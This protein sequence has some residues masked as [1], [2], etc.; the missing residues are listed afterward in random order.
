MKVSYKWLK[1]YVDLSKVTPDELADKMS[2]TGIEIEEVDNL[3]DGLKKI[4]VGEV[5]ECVDHENSDHLHVCQ[6][7]VGKETLQIVCGA[8]NVQKGQKVIVALAGARIAGNMKIKKGKIRGEV[9]HG[10]LCS[11]E[12][13]G[14]SNSV[15][16]KEEQ[17]GIYILPDNSEPGT[18][19][20]SLLDLDDSILELAIT[21]NRA[22]ALSMKGVSYEVGAI[23]NQEVNLPT[24]QLTEDNEV[25][26]ELSAKVENSE[27]SSQYAVRYIKDVQIKPSP[28]WLQLRLMNMGIRP[29]NNVIDITNYIMLL[30]GQPLHAYDADTLRGTLTVQHA[31]NDEKFVALNEEEYT[32][33]SSDIVI[34]DDDQV[35]ALAGIMGSHKT[36]VTPKTTNICLESALFDAISIRKTSQ[37]LHLRTDASQRFEKG[38]D[39]L[40]VCEALDVAASMISDLGSGKVAKGTNFGINQVDQELPQITISLNKIN[41]GLG[42]ELPIS[43]VEMILTA[44][45][46]DYQVYGEQFVITIPSRRFDLHIEADIVEEIGRLYG[47]NNLPNKLPHL[48]ITPGKRSKELSFIHQTH[49]KLQKLGLKETINYALT[50]ENKAKAFNLSS[51][52]LINLSLPMS[53][54]RSVLR[55]NIIS[56]LLDTLQ[57]NIARKNNNLTIYEIGKI[58]TK[59][60][61]Y[62]EFN[63]L[64][65]AMIGATQESTWLA[66]DK[67]IDFYTLKGTIE[68]YLNSLGLDLEIRYVE[69]QDRINMHPYQTADIV[70]G[71]TCIG[72]LGKV[73]PKY[74]KD[75]DLSN[76]Y[77]SEIDLHKLLEMESKDLIAKEI[78]KFPSVS[79][80]VAL[81][82]DKNINNAQIEKV[83]KDNG[84]KYLSNIKIFDIYAGENI[85]YDKKS[86]A[87]KLQFQKND[88][89]LVDDEIEEIM[90]KI[91]TSL[92]KELDVVVR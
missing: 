73:H 60:N 11:L 62:K 57:Y 83:I 34:C 32:L 44:L 15:I 68:T 23:Y 61:N 80:D 50:I 1:E 20:F 86:M 51:Y 54:E 22:D 10:M 8:P 87:Y 53:E 12:E 21:P 78:S 26:N 46:F 45:Q 70:I 6:V 72:Y 9:S 47:Y 81:L 85:A 67:A 30:F 55:G 88:S 25:I 5:V 64:G 28:R 14:F 69:N 42:I 24:Y 4:V 48:T 38:I 18:E 39:K 75:F 35:V 49:N 91:T 36:S 79:R 37:R 16:P 43:E 19:V 31:S 59:E 41:Q 52:N 92:I 2:R 82:V 89:T 7:N 13:L 66:K 63:H 27:L 71:N 74:A 65:I 3:Q 90:L 33:N 84:G 29:I 77:V 76:V 56:G 40:G 58:F 17:D